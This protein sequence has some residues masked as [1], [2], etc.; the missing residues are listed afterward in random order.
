MLAVALTHC[1]R[2]YIDAR[3]SRWFPAVSALGVV[4]LMCVAA[5][6]YAVLPTVSPGVA[7]A[8]VVAVGLTVIVV[9]L[10]VHAARL[11]RKRRRLH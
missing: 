4:V 10:D 6:N 9:I 11:R 7:A 1:V 5:Y 3:G 8:T 2:G